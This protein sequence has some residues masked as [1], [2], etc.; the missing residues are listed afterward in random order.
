MAST[1]SAKT[2]DLNC[3]GC[4]ALLEL[5]RGFAGGVCR[6]S[7]C[8]TLMTVPRLDTEKAEAL[9]RAERPGEAPGAR[10]ERPERPEAPGR[11]ASLTRNARPTSVPR[12]D[13]PSQPEAEPAGEQV[14]RTASGR[15]VRVDASAVPTAEAKRKAIR[16]ATV[17]VFVL[18]VGGV[19]ALCGL[20]VT[21][22][23]TQP[24]PEQIAAQTH[25]PV[26]TY[27]ASANPYAIEGPNLL[28]LP[29]TNRVALV[30]DPGGMDE[31]SFST[32]RSALLDGLSR[33]SD[34]V[35]VSVFV[36]E[37]DGGFRALV[38]GRRLGT[39]DPASIE[40][41]LAEAT[42]DAG[43]LTPAVSVAMED[44]PSL[45]IVATGRDVPDAEG[46]AV[47]LLVPADD[48]RF[49]AVLIDAD[50]FSLEDI[51]RRTNG[52]YATLDPDFELRDWRP[53]E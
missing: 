3:P 34:A 31:A 11:R 39:V 37:D 13:A 10:R 47:S 36:L 1:T 49:D 46:E 43:S 24:T 22:L 6:C 38:D 53:V 30:F 26:H 51:A 52:H 20:A 2:I 21:L 25:V 12:G 7:T 27:D 33:R 32:V 45:L 40:A 28:G 48:V 8:G 14:Y 9:V 42:A 16:A 23:V 5:D 35:R 29:L 18:V 15:E 19:L 50:S 17:A 41:A 44:D 4:S